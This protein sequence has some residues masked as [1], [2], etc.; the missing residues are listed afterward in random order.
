MATVFNSAEEIL[1]AVGWQLGESAWMTV[2]Q[3]RV[4]KFADATND[5]QWI[6]IDEARA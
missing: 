1:S 5:H 3:E 6:H 4:Q 2:T